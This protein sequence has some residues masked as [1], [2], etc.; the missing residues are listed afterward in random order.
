MED[1]K[2]LDAR[3]LRICKRCLIPDFIEDKER[4]LENYIQGIDTELRTQEGEY[5]KRLNA[6]ASCDYLRNGVCQLCGCFVVVR[7][8]VVHNY[9]PDSK[10]KWEPFALPKD[11]ELIMV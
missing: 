8:A 9:C 7:A 10:E 1:I 3:D 2:Q 4:F 5:E 11:N 6:C